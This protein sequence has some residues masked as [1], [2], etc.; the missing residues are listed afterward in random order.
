MAWKWTFEDL[1]HGIHSFVLLSH[2]F[3]ELNKTKQNSATLEPSSH[4][5]FHLLQTALTYSELQPP[6]V[7]ALKAIP[8]QRYQNGFNMANIKE[9]LLMLSFLIRMTPPFGD[10]NRAVAESSL[11][12]IF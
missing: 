7:N 9:L 6:A 10:L 1:E 4:E 2:D 5:S 12:F 3:F 8:C 11:K